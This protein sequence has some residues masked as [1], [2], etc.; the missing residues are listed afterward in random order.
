MAQGGNGDVIIRIRSDSRDFQSDIERARNQLNRL[1]G[2][3]NQA[4]AG[5]RDG[6]GAM[7]KL[8]SAMMDTAVYGGSAAVLMGLAAIPGKVRE[9]ADSYTDIQ[10]KLKLA[11]TSTNELAVA[12]ERLFEMSQKNRVAFG[13]TVQ[14]YS[15]IAMPLKD[16]GKSQE[17][18]L[19][20][21]DLVGKGLQVSGSSAG[22]A[23]STIKQ[24]S[25]AM[26]SGVLRGDEFNSIMENGK[27]VSMALAEG[28]GTTTGKLREMAEKGMLKSELVFNALMSQSDAM[29]KKFA[30]IAPTMEKA[31]VTIGNSALLEIGKLD[32]ATGA[33]AAIA[34]NLMSVANNMDAVFT[35]AAM[36]VGV[37]AA[38]M[39]GKGITAATGYAAAKVTAMQAT[40]ANAAATAQ[41][42]A[43][44]LAAAEAE[45]IHAAALLRQAEATVAATSGMARLS[46]V[47]NTLI[48]AQTRATAA[49]AA[50]AAALAASTA[51][52][53]TQAV[54]MRGLTATMGLLG[55]PAG[56]AMLAAG[57]LYYFA[58][59][60]N[61]AAKTITL[62]NGQTLTFSE[63]LEHVTEI[64]NEYRTASTSRQGAIREEIDNIIKL[65]A[66]RKI[67][68]QQ[69]LEYLNSID[70]E[71]AKGSE[72]EGN[73]FR[74]GWNDMRKRFADI[75]G[76]DQGEARAAIKEASSTIDAL[77]KKQ[78]DL[79]KSAE[80]L[81]T[82]LNKTPEAYEAN[83][84]AG[85]AAA[86]AT[87]KHAAATVEA[88][89][90]LHGH[91]DAIKSLV[92]G[93]T[94]QRIELEHG[95]L[96]ADYY[97]KRLQGLTDAE[98]RAA[99]GAEQYNTY[100]AERKKL[101][102]DAAEAAGG[103]R[104]KY[105]AHL[106][107]L[108]LGEKASDGIDA[109][110]S[111]TDN[112]VLASDRYKTSIDAAT[113]SLKRQAE[114]AKAV[115]DAASGAVVPDAAG[116][117][118]A[119]T[120]G[121][122]SGKALGDPDAKTAAYVVAKLQSLGWTRNQSIGIAAN[123]KQESEF[124]PNAEGDP[125][126]KTGIKQAY[127]I[128][129]W[130]PDRQRSFQATMGQSI[131]GSS[132]DTQ[133]EFLSKE[134]FMKNGGGAGKR[135][136]AT[137]SAQSAAAIFSKFYERPK[138]EAGEMRLRAGIANSIA[139]SLGDTVPTF[140]AVASEA[141]KVAPAIA[142]ASPVLDDAAAKTQKIA[143]ITV[144]YAG[145]ID[146]ARMT[147]AQRN[148]LIDDYMSGQADGL[149]KT[150]E[151]H[152]RQVKM[153]TAEY[154]AWEL[155]QDKFIG[156]DQQRILYAEQ[157]AEF[158]AEQI[159]LNKELIGIRDA[160]QAAQYAAGLSDKNLTKDQIKQLTKQKMEIVFEG[161]MKELDGRAEQAT[162][163]ADAYHRLTMARDGFTQAQ[164][165]GQIGW[166]TDVKRMEEVAN[167]NKAFAD[168]F[169]SDLSS[170]LKSG[171]LNFQGFADTVISEITRL[172]VVK[173][174]MDSLFGDSG[175]AGLFSGSADGGVLGNIMGMMGMKAYATGGAFTT[176]GV[177]AYANGGAFHNTVLHK[178]TQFF[179]NGGLAVAGEA[180]A[181]AVM[182]LTRIGGKLGVMATGGG[183]AVTVQPQINISVI[184]N[185]AK[186]ETKQQ[187]EP[188]ASG[189]V[190][191]TLMIDQIEGAISDRARRG[192]GLANV[193]KRA[194]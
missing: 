86:D 72:F 88:G 115:L 19:K 140:R 146:Q 56:V 44:A 20:F 131:R 82:E 59:S 187:A 145:T 158:T 13:D 8:K 96:A 58:E 45:S 137:D 171:E 132:V 76:P 17:E 22:E 64:S 101:N 89:Q 182:P 40:R 92:E 35:G 184:N 28:L 41:S 179:A 50:H 191:M 31:W 163:T 6:A 148:A 11:T 100:L 110:K 135:I 7:A 79:G 174:L 48:P 103:L 93:L 167:V 53:S 166:E 78:G 193:F 119:A 97:A 12:N 161:N 143:D 109:A 127:G 147:E 73:M 36:S 65:A 124:R 156:G 87:K 5:L 175:K 105:V 112:M 138:D 34:T 21:T 192:Q 77:T 108:G 15:G 129:Q 51:A 122:S 168:S 141:A 54:V 52:A 117:I 194:G 139:K 3:A 160:G 185:G 27:A 186:I 159:A 181:E 42:A 120:S 68:A 162:L 151:D 99:I 74:V 75:F 33:S 14:L 29:N 106:E 43:T 177:Q 63:T 111:A 91:G 136:K 134:L 2:S 83:A 26:A 169:E 60:N 121:A 61:D 4:G 189:G 126:K 107:G 81:A 178:P 176:A 157:Q 113:E 24:L 30:Q 128:A 150:A 164:I 170:A 80:E 114:A 66:Q 180:G 95:K 70:A 38:I 130:H 37:L 149:V 39:G 183:N 142:K 104:D 10:S 18:I 116:A 125:D 144:G 1:A 57:A 153:T 165:N 94:Q 190:N 98:A 172:Q 155:L 47:Q 9:A 23:A 154:R 25:Q 69:Q 85:L 49:A 84:K 133:L 46:V 173:P 90:V 62:A 71:T 32:Q 16:A 55:G 188:N 67:E 123:I 152:L 118:S 102:T